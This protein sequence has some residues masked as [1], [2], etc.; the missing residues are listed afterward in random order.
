MFKGL[1]YKLERIPSK[2]WVVGTTK[3]AQ[4]RKDV[5]GHC[6]FEERQTLRK[7][8]L[9]EVLQRVNDGDVKVFKW[10]GL[11]EITCPKERIVTFLKRGIKK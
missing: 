3:D 6:S 2:F 10:F 1:I 5:L 9:I 4:G 7:L 11:K 8:G